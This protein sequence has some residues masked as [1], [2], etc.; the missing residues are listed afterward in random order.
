MKTLLGIDRSILQAVWAN[1]LSW[2]VKRFLPHL[3]PKIPQAISD[4]DDDSRENPLR[5]TCSTGTTKQQQQQQQQELTK[6]IVIARPGGK[7]QLKLITLKPGIATCGFNIEQRDKAF[8][9]SLVGEEELPSDCILLR[10]Q[11]F[12]V[13]YAD[14]CIR[15]GLYES[16]KEYVGYPIVPG[17]DVAGVVERLGSKAAEYGFHVGDLVYGCTLFGAYSSRV[18][19]P[20]MQ[21]RKIPKSI[22]LTHAAAL[23]AVSL[24]ALYALFLAGHWPTRSKYSNKSI[25][26]HS[27]AGGV[28]SMLVQMAKLVGCSPIVGVVGRSNKVDAAKQLGCDTVIDK[29][30]QNLWQEAERASPN[31][32]S[33]IMDSNGVSTLQQS[34]DHVAMTGRL[35]VFGFHTNL[36]V[37]RDMLSPLEWFRMARRMSEMPKFDPMHMG[38]QNKSVLAFNLSFFAEEREMLSE[39]F[40]QVQT[41]LEDG[42][43]QVPRVVEMEMHN[44]ADAHDLI[45]SGRSVGKIVLS[46]DR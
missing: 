9:H 26:I 1:V 38:G 44:I 32:Y 3:V 13:N 21:L 35:I 2:F 16:A 12:S 7:E 31:G 6:C 34:Y 11:A 15:W 17:F 41:W 27:A 30:T 22:T 37:G 8:T 42:L 29:S 36:P 20:A 19:V 33:T 39:L 10:N 45:Q 28:G 43:L 5:K 24:T 40:D 23:P 25:L 14:C 18:L 46:T 4:C